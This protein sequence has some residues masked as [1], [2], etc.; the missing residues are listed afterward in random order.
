MADRRGQ[1]EPSGAPSIE[2]GELLPRL[3]RGDKLL[4]LDVRNQDEY[5]SWKLEPRTPVETVH[6]PYFDFIEDQD[7]ALARVPRDRELV[8]LCAKGGSSEMVVELLAEAGVRA[9]QRRGR[10]DRLRDLPGAR[11]AA[12]R[13]RTR[14]ALRDL[15]GQPP[16]QGLPVVRGRLG[17]RGGGRRSEPTR[18][19]VRGLRGRARRPHRAGARHPHPRR[20]RERRAG[21]RA[22]AGRA[23]LRLRGRGLRAAPAR[24]SARRR[25]ADPAGRRRGRGDRGARHPHPRPHPRLDLVPGGRPLPADRRHALR[26]RAW[27]GPTSAATWSSGAA[28]STRA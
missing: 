18:R 19:V 27:A 28:S 13:Q 7:E 24:D 17:R 16:R 15:A 20:P 3:D 6:V 26:A 12:A 5:E 4:L 11:R 22:P 9:A 2:V 25:P 8:V 1:D 14:P 23:L 21:A 10:H